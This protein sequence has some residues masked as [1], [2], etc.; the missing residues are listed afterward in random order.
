MSGIFK[1]LDNKN[2]EEKDIR[3]AIYEI[4]C[5]SEYNP[6]GSS[7]EL[8]FTISYMYILLL[9]AK[10]K[11]MHL[12]VK[13]IIKEVSLHLK[14]LID[15]M[16]YKPSINEQ[17]HI[18]NN[19]SDRAYNCEANGNYDIPDKFPEEFTIDNITNINWIYKYLS[20]CKGGFNE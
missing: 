11:D 7:E 17:K 5:D 8:D 6:V 16:K 19:I 9:E 10:N 3:N 18:Y 1:F 12:F 14:T 4:Y 2:Y 15:I 20:D 13:D